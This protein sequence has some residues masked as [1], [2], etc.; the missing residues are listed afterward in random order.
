MNIFFTGA[1]SFSGYWFCQELARRGHRVYATFTKE[2]VEAYP[3]EGYVRERVER[4]QSCVTPIWNAA[5]GSAKFFEALKEQSWGAICL[6]GSFVSDHK[7][8]NFPVDHALE[9]NTRGLEAMIEWLAD[10]GS[11]PIYWTGTYYEA[12]EGSGSESFRNFS[13][14][15]LSKQLSWEYLCFYCERFQLPL[16]KFVMPNPFGPLEGRGFSTYLAKTWLRGD[17]ATVQT[18]DYVRDNAPVDLLAELYSQFVEK[19][20]SSAIISRMCPSCYAETQGDFAKRFARKMVE[21]LSIPCEL[22]FLE[23]SDF[24]EPMIRKNLDDAKALSHTWNENAFW[25]LLASWYLERY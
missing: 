22:K 9:K 17:I 6:H 12:N 19:P 14:Y 11:P 25:D 10:H 20:S 16:L 23:Q 15:A 7:S 24:S 2:S 1:S 3:K 8:A 18:P 13:T 4:L 21:R 5:S